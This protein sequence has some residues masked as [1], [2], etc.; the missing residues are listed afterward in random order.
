M[1]DLFANA[2]GQAPSKTTER[3]DS[4]RVR[5]SVMAKK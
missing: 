5:F 3:R 4:S 2:L 1:E